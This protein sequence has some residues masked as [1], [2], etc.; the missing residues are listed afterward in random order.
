LLAL[1]AHRVL[2]GIPA[3]DPHLP[4][5]GDHGA[6]VEGRLR[7]LVLADVVG[8]TVVVT[9]VGELFALLQLTVQHGGLARRVGRIVAVGVHTGR[10]GGGGLG[11]SLH[12]VGAAYLIPRTDPPAVRARTAPPPRV[13][14][15]VLDQYPPWTPSLLSF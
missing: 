9:V 10:I 5:Q 15:R 1:R 7:D 13:Q 2:L 14:R 6:A 4:A 11:C 8:E 12:R 3:R